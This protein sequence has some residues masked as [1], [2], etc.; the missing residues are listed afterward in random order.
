MKA[1]Q[2]PLLLSTK[3]LVNITGKCDRSVFRLTKKIREHY[4]KGKNLQISIQEFCEYMN[5]KEED[6]KGFL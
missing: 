4:Q 2:P 6:V 1:R 5:L 3:D